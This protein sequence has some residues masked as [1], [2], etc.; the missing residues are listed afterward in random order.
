PWLIA[1]AAALAVWAPCTA[2]GTPDAGAP[3]VRPWAHDVAV[4]LDPRAGALTVVDRVTVGSIAADTPAPLRFLLASGFPA[5]TA[6][7]VSGDRRPLPLQTTVLGAMSEHAGPLVAPGDTI[8]IRFTGPA[9]PASLLTPEGALLLPASGWTPRFGEQPEL[10]AVTVRAP[11]GWTVI[12]Q[13]RPARGSPARH[14][15]SAASVGL[16]V[17]AGPYASSSREHSGI[18][19]AA[20]LPGKDPARAG[21]LLGRAARAIDRMEAAAGRFPFP[22]L[23]LIESPFPEQPPSSLPSLIVLAPGDVAGKLDHEIAHQWWGCQVMA[24]PSSGSW[25]E[26]LAGYFAGPLLREA[27]DT[28]GARD[29][30][31][32]L[33]LRSARWPAEQWPIPLSRLEAAGHDPG[34][35]PAAGRALMVLHQLR[36]TLGDEPFLQGLRH[37]AAAL[38]GRRAGW[39]DVLAAFEESSGAPLDAF[40]AQWLERAGLPRLTLK[41]VSA[42]RHGAGWRVTGRIEQEG[43]PYRLSIPLVTAP[44]SPGAPPA[45]TAVAVTE[46]STPFAIDLDD[47]PLRLRLDPGH[48]VPR[49]LATGEVPPCLEDTLSSDRKLYVLPAGSFAHPEDPLTRLAH[50]AAAGRG[51]VVASDDEL[52]EADLAGRSL[53]ILGGPERNRVAG[54]VWDRLARRPR[55]GPAGLSWDEASCEGPGCSLLWSAA[56]PADPGRT[57]TLFA[58]GASPSGDPLALAWRHREDAWALFDAGGTIASSRPRIDHPRESVSLMDDPLGGAFAGETLAAV[59][60]VLAGAEPGEAAADAVAALWK[61]LGAKP[62]PGM[63]RPPEGYRIPFS[64]ASLTLEPAPPGGSAASVGLHRG[65]QAMEFEARPFPIPPAA[66]HVPPSDP[67]LL[68]EPEELIHVGRSPSSTVWPRFEGGVIL[69][70]ERPESEGSGLVPG[71]DDAA[72]VLAGLLQGAGRLGASALVV[73]RAVEGPSD[74]DP[75]LA[76]PPG[77]SVEPLLAWLPFTGPVP[78]LL[79]VRAGAELGAELLGRHTFARLASPPT[80]IPAASRFA[81]YLL[82]VGVSVRAAITRAGRTGA[83]LFAHIEGSGPVEDEAIV[84][85]ARYP[86]PGSAPEGGMSDP[87]RWGAAALVE[88]ARILSLEDVRTRRGVILALLDETEPGPASRALAGLLDRLAIRAVGSVELE[89]AAPGPGRPVLSVWGPP[90]LY[91]LA[92]AAAEAAGAAADGPAP[93][94]QGAG[95]GPLPRRGLPVVRV[96]GGPTSHEAAARL[97]LTLAVAMGG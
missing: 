96:T 70:L 33:A 42:A 14:A 15:A 50:M 44:A 67:S 89:I 49:R 48:H 46:A 86:G 36:R 61:E 69:T 80:T 65:A 94:P 85:A 62:L 76:F 64:I 13:G 63:A 59:G 47:R 83:S 41:G 54:M 66:T 52:R 31:A 57:V 97:A 35:D 1:A 72:A 39:H 79:A 26:G 30:R 56:S 90:S 91:E 53:L 71:R 10:H 38:A 32:R 24:S 27:A 3:P 73:I 22:K 55:L 37:A 40:A 12:T 93:G 6:A 84:L 17:A 23:D 58:G 8:E 43:E 82:D 2:S 81:P 68:V 77:G 60:T 19:L 45:Q 20:H 88:A 87:A 25:A 74:L 29:D 18:A 75:L 21:E 11:E 9:P 28:E 4:T 95:S 34:S 78:E 16:A 51:G 92:A 7:A 5:V